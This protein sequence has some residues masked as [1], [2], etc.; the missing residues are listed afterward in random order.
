M[1]NRR[2]KKVQISAVC[3]TVLNA[4]THIDSAFILNHKNQNFPSKQCGDWKVSDSSTH[5]VKEELN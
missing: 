4:E 5:C 1:W 3:M 2:P